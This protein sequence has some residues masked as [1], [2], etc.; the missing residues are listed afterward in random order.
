VARDHAKAVGVT[1]L[2]QHRPDK[3]AER[4]AETDRR[5]VADVDAVPNRAMGPAGCVALA[6][7]LAVAA[8]DVEADPLADDF[9]PLLLGEERVLIDDLA[10]VANG[11]C[12][13]GL[14]ADERGGRLDVGPRR[15]V[16]V[17]DLLGPAL[18]ARHEREQEKRQAQHPAHR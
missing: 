1:L 10:H 7:G 8:V 5:V 4:V 6:H 3:V 12:G 13:G 9:L 16:A 11:G 17:R 18:G 15:G 14:A 2:M